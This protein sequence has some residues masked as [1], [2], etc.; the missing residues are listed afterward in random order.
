MT[1]ASFDSGAQQRGCAGT[2]LGA[3]ASPNL[4][5]QPAAFSATH[6]ICNIRG[7]KCRGLAADKAGKLKLKEPKYRHAH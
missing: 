2:L 4:R 7:R 5:G 3:K 1:P 6:K